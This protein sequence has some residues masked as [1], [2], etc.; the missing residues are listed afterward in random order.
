MFYLAVLAPLLR[1]LFKVLGV[2][3]NVGAFI[4]AH[5][6]YGFSL[7]DIIMPMF[8]FMSGAALPLALGRRLTDKGRVGREFHRYVWGRVMLLW[9]LGMCIQGN[10]LALDPLVFSPYNN[11]LQAIA[12]GYVVT[13]YVLMIRSRW[14]QFAMPLG[15]LAAYGIWM[16]F[17][18]DYTKTGNATVPVER[19]ILGALLPSGSR[20]VAHVGNDGYTW[21]LPSFVFPA[22]AL[23]G[24]HSTQ[25]LRSGFTA[26]RKAVVL[27][28]SGATMLG[29]GLILEALGVKTVKHIFT[30][31]FTLQSIGWCVLALFVLYVATDIM[32]WRWGSG[33]LLLF[34]QYALVA[35]LCESF[36]REVCL[37]LSKRLFSGVA[38]V[39][40]SGWGDVVIAI[41]FGLI[42]VTVLVIR[43]QL[44]EGGS[45]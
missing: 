35:Y 12:V 21:F 32:R 27:A 17:G 36:F 2:S 15:L 22:I 20:I 34:G 43:R 38:R 24:A 23:A 31:S 39:V 9:M 26:R 42:V 4:L 40:P 1:P 37:V 28:L 14:I 3:D 29:A 13:A 8:I 25:L 18:G 45:K 33:P 6:W 10:L 11:T 5:P 16:H 19:M 30:V 44:R 7:Y 41:G